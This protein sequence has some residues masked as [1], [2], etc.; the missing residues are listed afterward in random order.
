MNAPEAAIKLDRATYIGGS[1]SASILG[2]SK[3]R[4]PLD[5]YRLKVGD[6]FGDE[7]VDKQREKVFRRGKRLEPVAIDM[8][9]EEHPIKVTRRS[10]EDNPNRYTDPE[11]SF[12]KAEVDFEFEVTE[13]LVAE[14]PEG[15]LDPSLIGTIQNGEIKTVNPLA[16]G[17]WGEEFTEEVPIDYAAQSM[18]GLMVTGRQVCLYGTLVGADNLIIYKIERDDDTIAGMREKEVEFWTHNV[19]QRIAPDPVNMDDIKTLFSRVRGYPVEIDQ[20]TAN[21]VI[22]F[23]ELRV[24][25]RSLE[26]SKEVL[27]FGICD[28]VWRAWGTQDPDATMD[29]VQLIFAGKPIA[30]WNKTPGA[31]LD[32][33]R[34]KEEHPEIISQYTKRHEYRVIR[35]KKR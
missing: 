6:Y 34:L 12:L 24:K 28:Y 11:Y 27:E 16:A 3:W 33:K 18:H 20:K 14:F 22:Q 26:E 13:N 31:Y 5:T 30:T 1:D 23:Q 7:E 17:A 4:T 2:V 32:Q 25:I 29:N 21:A 10:T 35:I 19:C 15:F 9:I 8:L